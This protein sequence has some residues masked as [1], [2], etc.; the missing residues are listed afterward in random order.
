MIDRDDTDERQVR[1]DTM[2]ETFRAAQQRRLVERGIVLWNR[3]EAAQTAM[4]WAASR[5]PPKVH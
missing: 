5:V 4:A 3:A 2:I 1:I